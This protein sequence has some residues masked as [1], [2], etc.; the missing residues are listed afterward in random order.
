MAAD[1][2]E[3]V[4]FLISQGHSEERAQQIAGNH[5]DAVRA[6]FEKSKGASDASKE[7]TA[8]QDE[9]ATEAKESDPAA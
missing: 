9:S 1:H 3:L 4:E 2:D 6:D 7:K 8:S 5:P